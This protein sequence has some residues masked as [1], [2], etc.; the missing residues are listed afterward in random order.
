MKK[1][2][3]CIQGSYCSKRNYFNDYQEALLKFKNLKRNET[4]ENLWLKKDTGELLNAY[5]KR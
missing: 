4:V 5:N 3:L 1:Y 2:V